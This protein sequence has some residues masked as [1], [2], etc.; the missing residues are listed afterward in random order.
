MGIIEKI[1]LLYK[2]NKEM[3]LYIFFGG[4]TVVL[5]IIL[6]MLF[7]Y[8]GMN[9]LVANII[10]WLIVVLFAFVTNKLW[11]FNSKVEGLKELIIQLFYFYGGR[12]ITL[13]LEEV[14][15]FIFITKLDNPIILVKL[16]AQVLVIVLNYFISKIVIF[17]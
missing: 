8:I 6:F 7:I 16:V 17:K 14:I 15:L 4:L 12:L 3:I 13:I 9:E 5:S 1:E 2:K 10:A 11:V